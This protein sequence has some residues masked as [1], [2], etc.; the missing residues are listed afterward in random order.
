[1]NS[2]RPAQ[3]SVLIVANASPS[4]IA[5]LRSLSSR[6]IHTIAASWENETV[7]GFASRYCD[8]ELVLPSPYNDLLNYKDALLTVAS[9]ADVRT[10]VPMSDVDAYLLSKYLQEFEDL[11]SLAVPPFEMLRNVQDRM[12]LFEIAKAAGVPVP[13]TQLLDETENANR[14]RIIKSRY[15]VLANGYLST[16]APNECNQIKSVEY[17]DTDV[18]PDRNK[19]YEEMDHV[20]IVQEFIPTSNEYLFGALY[21][22]GEPVATF[23]HRQVRGETYA[24]GGG[25]FRVSVD[26]P[27]L[28]EVGRRLLNYLDWHGVACIEYME[29]ARTGELKLTEINPRM[30]RSLAFA[31]QSGADFPYYYWLL[32]TG[33]SGQIEPKYQIDKGGHLL[34]GE[35]TYLASVLFG[36]NPNVEKPSLR[37]TIQDIIVSCY[38]HPKFDYLHFDDLGPFL[39]GAANSL[40]IVDDISLSDRSYVGEKF[41][42]SSDDDRADDSRTQKK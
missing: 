27:R 2:T 24:G 7:P 23:Q 26:I 6:G 15:N 4:V 32:A 3:E 29:D 31:V 5:C 20:P 35:L 28:E 37:K 1:M 16:Y 19:I 34:F 25:S 10:I 18:E 41:D 11:V 42:V 36:D 8:E 33:R 38:E 17:Y 39:R 12:R 30:W 22:H 13:E 21:D 9:R 40:P 14:K